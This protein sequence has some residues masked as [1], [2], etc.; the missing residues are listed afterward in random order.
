MKILTYYPN[1]YV[2]Y[3][4][5]HA[6][7][8]IHANFQS[9]TPSSL[10]VGLTSKP[11]IKSSFFK[12]FFPLWSMRFLLKVFS[13]QQLQ[14][15]AEKQLVKL[16][17]REQPDVVYLYPGVSLGV[18]EVLKAKGLTIVFEAINCHDKFGKRIV[19]DEY[20]RLGLPLTYHVSESSVKQYERI[21]SLSDFVFCPS[22]LVKQSFI[23]MGVQESKL[24]DVSYGLCPESILECKTMRIANA[25]VTF[26]FTGTIDVRKGV[27]LLLDYWIEAEVD[28]ELLLVGRINPEIEPL[29]KQKLHGQTNIRHFPFTNDLSS[30]YANADVFVLASIEEGS[31][32]VT[33]L[34]L[35]AGLPVLATPMG[36]G[37]VVVDGE[38]GYLIEPYDKQVWIEKIQQLASDATL[39][40][41]MSIKAQQTAKNYTWDKVGK[42]RYWTLYN[43]VTAQKEKNEIT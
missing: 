16:I 4:I 6:T 29:L 34:A 19:D 35:G 21:V 33:Y 30:I 8:Q 36:G 27:L 38:E 9:Y 20:M 7:F 37:G 24:L 25:K 5:P 31:P 11:S 32:L 40:R 15:Y 14:R 17:E 3:G 10:I 18:F 12:E 22:I 41:R 2:G 1:Y 43:A 26:V 28:A 13:L 23:D 39:R 42:S